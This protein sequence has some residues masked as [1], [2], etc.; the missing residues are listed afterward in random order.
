MSVFLDACHRKPTPY[1]PVWLMRQAGRYQP[2]YRAIREKVSFLE[3]CRNPDLCAQVAVQAVDDTGVDAAIV[4]AD[5][6]LVLEPLGIGFE[7][8]K[9]DGPRIAHPVRTGADVDRVATEIDAAGSLGYVME[10]VR[11]TRPASAVRVPLI[12]FSGAP[13]TLASYVIEGGGSRDYTQTK[14]FMYSDEGAWHELMKRLS[15]AI[16]R[17]LVAQI[18]AGAEAVQLFDSWIGA[19]GPDDYARYVQPHVASIFSA[20]RGRVPA[21]HFGT[22]NPAL[23]PLLAETGGDV[24]GVDQRADLGTTWRAL[25][26]VA[27]QGNLDPVTL[28]GPRDVMFRKADA[29]LA[30]AGGRPGHVFNLGHGVLPGASIEQVRALV[31]HV[32]EAS[33]R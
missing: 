6:L 29:V 33:S 16:T 8:T 19:L 24:I 22:G 20:I 13:F 2:S 3:L 14:R 17:Y 7:F 21:I 32:H 26:D 12:G 27:V 4:F 9:D 25:G 1:T 18:D 15:S 28:L 10:S 30:S 5:I 11:R 23:Y 31:D